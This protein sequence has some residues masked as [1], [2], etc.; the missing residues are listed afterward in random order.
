MVERVISWVVSILIVLY[1]PYMIYFNIV[2]F[3][4]KWKCRKKKYLKPIRSCH[5][6]NC[7]FADFC[8]DYEHIYT[9]E[10]IAELHKMIDEMK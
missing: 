1:I 2:H 4:C 8:E 6:S 5:E 9:A 10:E 7:K 3:V